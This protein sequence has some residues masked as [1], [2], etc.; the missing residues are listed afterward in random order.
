MFEVMGGE[1]YVAWS[2]DENE[3]GSV[4]L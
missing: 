4:G 1:R 2:M 3:N